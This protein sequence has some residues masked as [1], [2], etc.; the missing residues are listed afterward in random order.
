M[1]DTAKSLTAQSTYSKRWAN[2][3]INRRLDDKDA[4]IQAALLSLE[5]HPAGTFPIANALVFTGPTDNVI[6]GTDFMGTATKSSGHIKWGLGTASVTL[7]AV[8]PGKH[9]IVVTVTMEESSN[10]TVASADPATGAIAITLGVACSVADAVLAINSHA[11]AKYMVEAAVV[12][13]ETFTSVPATET[14][15]AFTVT[16][17]TGSIFDLV[18]AGFG[19]G[20]GA[21]VGRGITAVTDGYVIFDFSAPLSTYGIIDTQILL[22]A[23]GALCPPV[24]SSSIPTAAPS[25]KLLTCAAPATGSEDTDTTLNI[26]A[27]GL[28]K[29]L[30]VKVTTPGVVA[31]G[32]YLITAIKV[33]SV[34]VAGSLTIDVTAAAGTSYVLDVG[35]EAGGY[36]LQSTSQNLWI[37]LTTSAATPSPAAVLTVVAIYDTITI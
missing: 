25:E 36:V 6:M 27:N 4:A 17:G 37:T 9:D 31:S 3:R 22:R 28:L 16:G 33:G 2:Q 15:A 24:C 35:T 26:P 21:G 34:T 11:T 32:T 30:L 12:G 14:V 5:T 7:E 19:L 8:L 1:A 10:C 20:L 13:A 23:D 18:I 29:T